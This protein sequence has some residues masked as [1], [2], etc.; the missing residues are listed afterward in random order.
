MVKVAKKDANFLPFKVSK[1]RFFIKQKKVVCWGL[2]S[3]FSKWKLG[4]ISIRLRWK[5]AIAMMKCVLSNEFYAIFLG[6]EVPELEDIEVLLHL[7]STNSS[8]IQPP[9]SMREKNSIRELAF[10]F[11]V[12]AHTL[13]ATRWS[14]LSSEWKTYG[15]VL[16]WITAVCFDM[17]RYHQ[18]WM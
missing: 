16:V 6:F 1:A 2:W 18:C 5:G 13:S 10:R 8:N 4:V 17:L 7:L 14:Q 9:R 11:I 15:V 12:L 3:M